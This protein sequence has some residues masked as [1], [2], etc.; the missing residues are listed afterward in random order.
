MRND[1]RD[2]VRDPSIL[3]WRG[4]DWTPSLG[5]TTEGT[6]ECVSCQSNRLLNLGMTDRLREGDEC[7]S[8]V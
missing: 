3:Y 7:P 8:T 2:T 6:V 1:E 4:E 5:P